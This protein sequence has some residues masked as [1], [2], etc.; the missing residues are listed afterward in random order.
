MKHLLG[1]L[2][3]ATL[4]ACSGSAPPPAPAGPA[5]DVRIA[6]LSLT[7]VADVVW[8]LEVVNGLGAPVWQ[9]RITS[10]GHGDGAGSASYVGT[11]DAGP[12]AAENTVRVWVVG[13]YAA[14]VG[15]AAAGAFASGSS[16]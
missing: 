8:D 4:A 11:C 16:S 2:A 5:L 3:L 15:S 14:P 10:T 9:R 12:G 6:A 7:G 1:V 13:L